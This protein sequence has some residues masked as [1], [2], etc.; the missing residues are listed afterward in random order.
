GTLDWDVSDSVAVKLVLADRQYDSQF[1]TDH[2]GSPLGGQEVNG[3]VEF[4]QQTV[5]L[6]F[7]GLALN[8][9]LD[10]TAGLFLYESDVLSA[11][12]VLLP[13]FAGPSGILVNGLN[14]QENE[15][16]SIYSQLV[17]DLSD[18]TSVTLGLRYSE[19]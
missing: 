19:D 9:R 5:E 14:V 15:N 10:W 8:E 1:A 7:S 2:D 17:Y 4:D 18:R 16:R 11:Q 13:A 12:T 3:Y 6:Q